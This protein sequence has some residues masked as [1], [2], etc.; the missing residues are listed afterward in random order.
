MVNGL[1]VNIAA[2]ESKSPQQAGKSPRKVGEVKKLSN[3]AG[4]G[5]TGTTM[6]MDAQLAT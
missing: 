2:I 3:A 5:A 6:T 4:G 1:P